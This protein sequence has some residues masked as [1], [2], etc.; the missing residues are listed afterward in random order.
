MRCTGAT[1]GLL[2]TV[3]I[4][5]EWS[6]CYELQ[7]ISNQLWAL[8]TGM[9]SLL[10]TP[11]SVSPYSCVFLLGCRHL[12]SWF[13]TTPLQWVLHPGRPERCD[14]AAPVWVPGR[15]SFQVSVIIYEIWNKQHHRLSL[16]HRYAVAAAQLLWII[17]TCV[18]GSKV[19]AISPSLSSFHAFSVC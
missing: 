12:Q 10:K 9:D 13:G 4:T 17:G 14:A 6:Q 8:H 16:C 7:I 3:Q 2:S 18:S 5:G 11:L 1:P 19:T 15:Q